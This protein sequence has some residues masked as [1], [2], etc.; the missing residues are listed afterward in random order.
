MEQAVRPVVEEKDPCGHGVQSSFEVAPA[1]FENVPVGH[2]RHER[3]PG[4]SW[5]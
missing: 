3:E 1:T 4:V 5:Y 2:F